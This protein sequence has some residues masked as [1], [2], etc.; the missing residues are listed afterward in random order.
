MRVLV[1][2][3]G[4]IADWG[5]AYNDSLDV[6]GD[7]AANIPRH[8]NQLT[9]DLH[10]GRTDAEK[11]IIG[12]VMVEP[13][14]YSRLVPIAGAK[15]ALKSMLKA[16]H[17]VRIVTSPWVSNPTCA[18]D[19]LNWIV[20]HYG[21][22][23]GARVIITADKTL[24]RGDILI[25]DKPEIHGECEPDWEH[26]LFDQPYNQDNPRRRLLD[27]TGWEDILAGY[28]SAGSSTPSEPFP[29]AFM[30]AAPR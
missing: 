7:E 1:D 5:R 3:D 17:D 4:V 30:E 25:D 22:H 26:V 24:V 12:A 29:G 28:H 27:W 14:F 23:W 11:E 21:S 16:G 13:G 10:A 2:M 6:F 18:S 8:Q 15:N 19:K 9:F 20:D